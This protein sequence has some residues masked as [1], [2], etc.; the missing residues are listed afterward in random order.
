MQRSGIDVIVCVY[1]PTLVCEC[2]NKIV[3]SL[4][5]TMWL[6]LDGYWELADCLKLENC[7]ISVKE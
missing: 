5:F 1:R 4:C 3:F 6:C 7:K 2:V